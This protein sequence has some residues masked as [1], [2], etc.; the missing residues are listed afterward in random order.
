MAAGHR[1]I[2][3]VFSRL[4]SVVIPAAVGLAL[5]LAL[6]GSR[7]LPSRAEGRKPVRAVTVVAAPSITVV[8]RV[9]GYG[10]VKPS[11]TWNAV[12]EVEGKIVKKHP[13]LEPGAILPAGAELFQIDRTDYEL[14]IA[15]LTGTVR[16]QE[17]A[18]EQLEVEKRN[19]ERL[20][21]V[22]KRSLTL[23]QE[24]LARKKELLARG[25]ITPSSVDQETRSVL[26]Q[27]QNV[28]RIE[29]DLALIP[30]RRESLKAQL[31]RDQAQLD[32]ARLD[33]AQTSIK[34]PFDARVDTVAV[35]L[36][37]FVRTGEVLATADSVASAE[38]AAQ[39]TI[40]EMFRLLPP[41]DLDAVDLTGNDTAEFFSRLKASVKLETGRGT[42]NWSGRV[43]R[44]TAGLDP[45]TRTVGIIVVVDEPYRS[46]RPP[47]RPPLVE[48]MYV[49]V[50]FTSTAKGPFVVVPRSS[51]H[52]GR[53]YVVNSDNVLE[54]RPVKVAF[55]QDGI[56]ALAEGVS[57]GELVVVADLV[58]AVEGMTLKP[59]EI[60]EAEAGIVAAGD[61][62]A[63]Q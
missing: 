15:Q 34:L 24:D 36:R 63:I 5:L 57:A 6:V 27:E 20:L 21:E 60:D 18:I 47:V 17:V 43:D 35:E 16:A 32:Q 23:A 12:A 61:G 2:F 49:R 56:V 44:T 3:L 28:A 31:A 50:E 7:D 14:R 38:I 30:T 48:N 51:L 39:V 1:A 29:N 13:R 46:A 53:V 40:D 25:V 37:Q 52:Q 58:P 33:L 22:E 9:S 62:G 19:S 42:V 4:L 45:K 10:I 8:P 41:V 26:Q 54:I 11:E 59:V 55:A